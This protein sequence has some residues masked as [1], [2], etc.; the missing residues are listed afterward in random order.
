MNTKNIFLILVVVMTVAVSCSKI[1]E[2]KKS[3]INYFT[4]AINADPSFVL[5]EAGYNMKNIEELSGV[6]A[7]IYT[8]GII[9]YSKDGEVLALVNYANGND[10][11]ASVEIDG[12]VSTIS[13]KS[14]SKGVTY[15]KVIVTP[16][17]KSNNCNYEIVSGIIKYY[18]NGTNVWIATIDFGDGTCDDRAIKTTA[19]GD[20][21][22]KISDYF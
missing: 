20:Y 7:N 6:Q 12:E 5:E 10:M 13:L 1:D 15:Y 18:K 17:V 8:E 21:T 14:S 3:E 22:F 2:E 9:E 4:D 16:L 19:K 11:Q